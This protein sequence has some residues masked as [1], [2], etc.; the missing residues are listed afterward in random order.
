MKHWYGSLEK[1]SAIISLS[2]A[3]SAPHVFVTLYVGLQE[4]LSKYVKKTKDKGKMSAGFQ[5][6][7]S[8]WLLISTFALTTNQ[9][10]EFR[11]F[12]SCPFL[13]ILAS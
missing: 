1:I 6:F 4:L 7:V 8:M 11:P 2:A 9:T 3:P 13:K 10:M 12:C 5:I